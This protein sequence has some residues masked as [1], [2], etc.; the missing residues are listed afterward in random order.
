MPLRAYT[1]GILSKNDARWLLFYNGFHWA[2]ISDHF[3]NHGVLRG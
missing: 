2:G 3:G 1:F